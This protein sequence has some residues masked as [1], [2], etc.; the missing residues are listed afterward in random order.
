MPH[1]WRDVAHHV[2]YEAYPDADLLPIDPPEQGQPIRA[3]IRR[4]G[5]D[6]GDG[7]FL[8]MCEEANDEIDAA[9]YVHR[10]ERAILDIEAVKAAF[11]ATL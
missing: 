9:E 8:F 7:L 4:C 2:I 5:R 6:V 11:E 10:L 3:F 1:K